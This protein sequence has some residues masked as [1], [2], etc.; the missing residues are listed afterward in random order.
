LIAQGY[1]PEDA[2][3]LIG[4]VVAQEI[5]AV[6]Q[7]EEAYNEQLYDFSTSAPQRGSFIVYSANRGKP[8]EHLR[9]AP[10]VEPTLEIAD[11]FTRWEN[12]PL[13]IPLSRPNRNQ[14]DLDTRHVVTR[15]TLVHRL[16]QEYVY[17]IYLD[18][19]LIGEMS[20][21]VDPAHLLKHE[22][23]T[24]WIGITIGEAQ[25]RGRGIG[26]HALH[27][28]E[29][30]IMGHGLGRIEL[31]VF[32][33]NLPARRLYHKLGYQEIGKVKEFTYWQGRMWDDIRLDKYLRSSVV[34]A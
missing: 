12:D 14:D 34:H 33:F 31:G 11:A 28:L 10:L 6:M 17:L 2:R 26:Q 27:Y 4:N 18:A 25:G 32:E 8:M 1:A 23:A 16:H 3:R 9:F 20:Y 19:H 24:A 21:H 22:C 5:F 7:R 13:L 29:H 15:D 30:Q